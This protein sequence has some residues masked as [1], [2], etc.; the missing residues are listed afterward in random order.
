MP[1]NTIHEVSATTSSAYAPAA[2]APS[3]TAAGN[4]GSVS[5]AGGV[6][7]FES[8]PGV[9]RLRPIDAVLAAVAQPV[10]ISENE[11]YAQNLQVIALMNKVQVDGRRWSDEAATKASIA[12]QQASF[13][14]IEKSIEA[15]KEKLE[16][17]MASTIAK[18]VGAAGSIA[19]AG[20]QIHT[21]KVAAQQGDRGRVARS[22]AA[23]VRAEANEFS[24][25]AARERLAADGHQL[26]AH[27]ALEGGDLGARHAAEN[28]SLAARTRAAEAESKMHQA[29]RDADVDE[30]EAGRL[31]GIES[32]LNTKAGAIQGIN[33]AGG[34]VTNATSEGAQ[35]QLEYQSREDELDAAE[36]NA[37]G[38]F[39]AAMN[40]SLA[41]QS[42][43]FQQTQAAMLAATEQ[44]VNNVP[45]LTPSA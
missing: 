17:A 24:S 29:H 15:A 31:H 19:G 27:R 34:Q 7:G 32:H 30:A 8:S 2:E 35:A 1:S 10:N 6:P 40:K 23:G 4:L 13:D 14:S 28:A 3:W 18:G 26:E 41:E 16:G 42:G 22:D 21:A 5:D 25:Q 20:A 36:F 38:T 37:G 45:K 44:V 33:M 43:Q 11:L 39:W 9:H 12:S